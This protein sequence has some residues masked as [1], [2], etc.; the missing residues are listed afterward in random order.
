MRTTRNPDCCVADIIAILNT[1]SPA[2]GANIAQLVLYT[3]GSLGIHGDESMMRHAVGKLV[4]AK[5]PPVDLPESPPRTAPGGQ[6]KL[7][8]RTCPFC[9][10]RQA[11]DHLKCDDCG[12]DLPR[13]GRPRKHLR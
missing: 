7:R 5:L 6:R 2:T 12:R 10:C 4:T 13:L 8:R 9:R 11:P 3:D 1:Y